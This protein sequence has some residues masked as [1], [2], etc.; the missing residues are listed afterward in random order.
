MVLGLGY[1]LV[2]ANAIKLM[3]VLSVTLVA[4]AGLLI[5]PDLIDRRSACSWP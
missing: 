3:I 2:H 5:T 1:S 4:L